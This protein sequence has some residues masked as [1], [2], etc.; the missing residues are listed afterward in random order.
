MRGALRVRSSSCR[1][2]VPLAA[3]ALIALGAC[4]SQPPLE[5]ASPES[6][7]TAEA[8]AD[9]PQ[10]VENPDSAQAMQVAVMLHAAQE[11]FDQGDYAVAMRE[12]ESVAT[13]TASPRERAQA[14]LGMALLRVLP[15]SV[16]TDP[17]AAESLL[18]EFERHVREHALR[19]E[20]GVDVVILRALA[21]SARELATLHRENR[22]LRSDLAARE[23]LIRKLRALSVGRD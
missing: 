23:E 11:A 14:L 13:G 8:P 22:A 3:L 18:G 10:T 21:S 15:A 17:Q 16:F 4:G 1:L 7:V 6:E 2:Q 20:F 19:D 9:S 5:P 12:W